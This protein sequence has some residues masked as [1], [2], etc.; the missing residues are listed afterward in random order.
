VFA[1]VDWG[2]I[3]VVS[4]AIFAALCAVIGGVWKLASVLFRIE[5][6]VDLVQA[7]VEE[8]CDD[9]NEIKSDVKQLAREAGVEV[10][11]QVAERRRVQAR[12]NAEQEN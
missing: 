1:Q 12:D 2:N 6:K 7:H 9:I 10:K 8:H 5:G 3:T 4:L 11:R